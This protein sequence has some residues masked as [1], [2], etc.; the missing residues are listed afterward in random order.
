MSDT[1]HSRDT[2]LLSR[3]SSQV[4]EPPLYKVV[5]LNDDFTPMDF[6]VDVLGKFFQ[7][8]LQEATRIMLHVHYQ[9]AGLCG[10]YPKDVAETKVAQVN[11]YARGHGYP[12]KCQLENN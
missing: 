2:E 5:L 8:S 12:L 10:I 6:V 3:S 1:T 11:Q 7:K 9:G 4:K